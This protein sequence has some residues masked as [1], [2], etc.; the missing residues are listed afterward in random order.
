MAREIER[1]GR[2][3]QEIL[4]AWIFGCH[5]SCEKTCKNRA[6]HIFVRLT[7]GSGR[8][9]P[10]ALGYDLIALSAHKTRLEELLGIVAEVFQTK[11]Q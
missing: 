9:A 4:K 2:L 11:Q 8:F 3:L 1:R 5:G 7:Q 6:S 10:C